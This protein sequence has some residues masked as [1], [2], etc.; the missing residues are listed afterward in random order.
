MWILGQKLRI[1][2]MQFAKH[3]KLKNKKDQSV[4]TSI[5]L[6]RGNKY[7]KKELQIQNS[8]QRLKA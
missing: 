6:R 8:E 1:P 4:D 3:M 2:K 5:L 7:P